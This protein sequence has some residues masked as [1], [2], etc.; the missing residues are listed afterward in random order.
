MTS[1]EARQG[2]ISPRDQA[3]DREIDLFTYRQPAPGPANQEEARRIR[4]YTAPGEPR[5]RSCGRPRVPRP[6]KTAAG[7][8]GR[9]RKKS[10]RTLRGCG[11]KRKRRFTKEKGLNARP[12]EA[13][14][15]IN[16]KS[17]T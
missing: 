5:S 2:E 7:S 4:R 6:G 17:A 8:A 16:A 1:Q 15:R 10:Q 3:A 9:P 11:L 13:A 12:D 14:R